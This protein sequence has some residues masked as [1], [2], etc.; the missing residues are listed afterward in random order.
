MNRYELDLIERIAIATEKMLHIL[1]AMEDRE[2]EKIEQAM[3]KEMA[4]NN[5]NDIIKVYANKD[6]TQK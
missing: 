5:P 2:Q 6:R 3:Q 4:L 1:Q